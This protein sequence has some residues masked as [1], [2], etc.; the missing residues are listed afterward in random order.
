[1]QEKAIVSFHDF[2]KALSLFELNEIKKRMEKYGPSIMKFATMVKSEIDTDILFKMLVGKKE[3]EKLCIIGMGKMGKRTRVL[4]PLLGGCLTYCNINT[5]R[6]TAPGQMT[7][8]DMREIY[9][10]LS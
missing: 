7:C 10:L 8:T 1:M 9:R 2:K 6:S 3:G 4:S 5:E